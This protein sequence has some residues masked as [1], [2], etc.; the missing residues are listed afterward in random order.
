MAVKTRV[1]TDKE[2]ETLRRAVFSPSV[3]ATLRR[4]LILDC[5]SRIIIVLHRDSAHEIW[6]G[7]GAVLTDVC[8][9]ILELDTNPL[10]WRV[11]RI[12]LLLI[13]DIFIN[14]SD[15]SFYD[16]IKHLMKQLLCK[17]S[18]RLSAAGLFSRR[19]QSTCDLIGG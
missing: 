16:Y 5:C 14:H 2:S 10:I 18:V 1:K 11:W 13:S 17:S 3:S 7:G 12:K 4:R 6:G 9:N 15:A 19:G 8:D